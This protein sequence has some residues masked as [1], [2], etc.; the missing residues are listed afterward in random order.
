MEDNFYQASTERLIPPTKDQREKLQ[1]SKNAFEKER[2]IINAVIETLE[3]EIS[4]REKVDSITET[5]NPEDFM[6]EVTVN[7][8]VCAI[9]RK[10]METLKNQVRMFDKSK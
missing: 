3:K 5:K 6:R 1:Q 10:N 4:F 9:L 7:K 2:P 8:Q